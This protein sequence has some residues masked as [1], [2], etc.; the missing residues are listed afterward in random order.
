MHLS[1]FGERTFYFSIS[2]F[3]LGWITLFSLYVNFLNY[4]FLGGG[5][6]WEWE[7][8]TC[9]TYLCLDWFTLEYTQTRGWNL[10]PWYIVMMLLPTQ[11]SSQHSLG[12]FDKSGNLCPRLKYEG[13]SW[14]RHAVTDWFMF[15]A[16][17]VL[18]S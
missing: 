8:M 15:Q 14:I 4:W 7:I 1:I 11:L 3:Y 16:W 2:L 9:S 12:H 5:R 18:E 6:G 17:F 13:S 10:Q